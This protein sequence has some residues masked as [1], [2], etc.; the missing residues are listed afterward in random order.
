VL[1]LNASKSLFVIRK[2][3]RDA[4]RPITLAALCLLFLQFA[5]AQ[6]ATSQA[7]EQI[8]TKVDEYM[9]A[10]VISDDFSGSLLIARDGQP[11]FNKSYGLASIELGVANTPQTV[12]RIASITKPFTA[13]AIMMLQERGK[14][15]IGDSICKYL[16]DCP[17]SWQP[18]T[19]KN[20]L[21]HTSGIPNYL[22]FPDYLPNI[23]LPVTHEKMIGTFRD[24]PLEFTPG[25][26][27]AYS[28]SGY[29]LLGVIIERVS[30]RSYGE[31]LQENIF[32]PLGM[33]QT[34]DFDNRSIIKNRAAGYSL[35][36]DRPANAIYFDP[37]QQLA[38][39]SLW[40]TTE[41]LLLFDRALY[42]EKLLSRKS[43]DEMFTLS[44][45]D[46]GYGW[47]VAPMF[48][49]P[50]IAHGGDTLGF[51]GIFQ[52]FTADRTT[53]ILL[54][55]KGYMNILTLARDIPAIV[56]GEEYE[57]PHKTK[58]VAVDAK[59]LQQYAG[60]YQLPTS[61]ILKITLEDGKLMIQ[62]SSNTRPKGEL[63]AEFETTFRRTGVDAT[64]TFERD[65]SG[66]VTTIV[67]HNV[68]GVTT[69]ASKIN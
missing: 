13:T 66:R 20:L 16:V 26:K 34:G 62:N 2:K 47:Q 67:I 49:R 4:H 15:K 14:L 45:A 6:S 55:N 22:N 19:V 52:R 18:I 48:G 31:F 56:F 30:G 51:M 37:T 12:F 40:S 28:N 65:T 8:A 11:I 39:G 9:T 38:T 44:K 7:A 35:K 17:A 29:Y 25:G 1:I 64:F 5:A 54:S 57:L 10:A 58:A 46:Y 63:F 24:K 42:T 36:N 69:K 23:A 27:F 3:F 60:E 32:A 43:L 50:L 21:T 53:I 33:K 68:N 61:V 59:I 41:D